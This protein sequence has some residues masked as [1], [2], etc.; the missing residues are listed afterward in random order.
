YMEFCSFCQK[1]LGKTSCSPITEEEAV[2]QIEELDID[3]EVKEELIRLIQSD[4]MFFKF[5]YEILGRDIILIDPYIIFSISK[6]FIKIP[7]L[8]E[9]LKVIIVSSTGFHFSF[10]EFIR[11]L[12]MVNSKEFIK[13]LNEG[14][15]LYRENK[16]VKLPLI[17]EIEPKYNLDS[18]C[19]AL[20]LVENETILKDIFGKI[21]F[22]NFRVLVI[23]LRKFGLGYFDRYERAINFVREVFLRYGLSSNAKIAY[24]EKDLELIESLKFL[25]M[26]GKKERVRKIIATYQLE[27]FGDVKSLIFYLKDKQMIDPFLPLGEL[28]SDEVGIINALNSFYK[29]YLLKD[30][31]SFEDKEI[32]FLLLEKIL[33]F[34]F[35]KYLQKYKEDA[36]LE[37]LKEKIFQG[38]LGIFLKPYL[39]IK[40]PVTGKLKVILKEED[41]QKLYDLEEGTIVVTKEYPPDYW[42]TSEPSAII[43][44][45]ESLSKYSHALMRAKDKIP[46][47]LC[48]Y[49]GVYYFAPLDGR[50]VEIDTDGK[51]TLLKKPAKSYFKR[52]PPRKITLPEP[53]LPFLKIL[54]LKDA[55]NPFIFGYKTARLAHIL[56]E[57]FLSLV[58]WAV[59]LPFGLYKRVVLD[60]KEALREIKTLIDKA[61]KTKNWK[62]FKKALDNIQNIFLKNIMI[63]QDILEEVIFQLHSLD[64]KDKPL[65]LRSSTNAEDLEEYPSLG[66]GM[67]GSFYPVKIGKEEIS[68][69]IRKCYASLFKPEAFRERMRSGINHLDVYCGVIVQELIEPD[70]SF[71]A[72]IYSEDEF[73]AEFAIGF[74]SAILEKHQKGYEIEY[75][76]NRF[77]ILNSEFNTTKIVI[78]GNQKKEEAT[79]V[80]ER[81]EAI[82]I[83][84]DILSSLAKEF[85]KLYSIFECPLNVE[86]L[87]KDD[88]I[89]IVQVRKVTSSSSISS[90]LTSKITPPFTFPHRLD[91]VYRYLE[92]FAL[93]FFGLDISKGKKI[94]IDV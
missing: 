73:K 57:G 50:Y 35:E 39:N 22:E 29:E 58:P 9:W 76:E 92:R 11:N 75:K 94:I 33:P 86:G 59:A 44:A 32:I 70:V 21:D 38:I 84:N 46:L 10:A 18:L 90:K 63:P 82:E 64:I 88:D 52:A 24:R 56:K 27:E 8:R 83:I 45:K 47:F 66:I 79:E 13:I 40:T 36:Y 43:I 78:E 80:E 34:L 5:T 91:K 23:K 93:A 49:F 19:G 48:G 20:C 14:L 77:N 54:S 12:Y 72:D 2:K 16:K 26:V 68:K 74:L 55:E 30:K 81:E 41:E 31:L 4:L 51:I 85:E 17:G 89:Y 71:V 7:F 60:N 25:G 37:L 62:E 67:Y 61:E 1:R 87:I 3:E 65:I 42:A 15:S 6:A 69:N 53:D 28:M